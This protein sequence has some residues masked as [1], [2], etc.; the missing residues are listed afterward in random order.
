M[1][2]KVAARH[3]VHKDSRKHNLSMRIKALCALKSFFSFRRHSEFL[4]PRVGNRKS[5]RVLARRDTA[6]H[7]MNTL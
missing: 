7:D 3:F 6:S 2:S 5:L 1:S 4:R